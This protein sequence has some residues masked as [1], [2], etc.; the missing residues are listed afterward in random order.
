MPMG[1]LADSKSLRVGILVALTLLLLVVVFVANS[2]FAQPSHQLASG[3]D[4]STC[5]PGP[6]YGT[7]P[8]SPTSKRLSTPLCPPLVKPLASWGS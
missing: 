6:A 5:S 4:F 2:P 1:K 7:T 3:P 8:A